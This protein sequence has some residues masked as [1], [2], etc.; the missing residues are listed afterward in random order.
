MRPVSSIASIIR[1]GQWRAAGAALACACVSMGAV[2]LYVLHQYSRHA[3]ELVAHSL[4]FASEPA[5]RFKDV[6][7]LQELVQQIAQQEQLAWVEVRDARGQALL[8]YER[9]PSGWLDEMARHVDRLFMPVPALASVD[10]DGLMLGA[11]Q[12]RSDGHFLMRYLIGIGLALGLCVF[13]TT[14]AI[15]LSSRRLAQSIMG[16]VNSFVELTRE[17]RASR[18]F[19]RRA[20]PTGVVEINALADDFNSLLDELQTQQRRVSARHSDLRQ[21]NAALRHA[22]LHDGLTQLPNRAYLLQRMQEVFNR[23]REQG[24]RAGLLFVDVDKFKQ[25]N[26][27]FGHEAGDAFLKELALRLQASV[28]ETDFVARHGG[29]EF[30]VMLSPLLEGS[31]VRACAARI[32]E[33]LLNPLHLKSGAEIVMGVTIGAAIFP[34]HGSTIDE[35]IHSADSAMYQAKAN[36]RGSLAL[37]EGSASTEAVRKD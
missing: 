26:D 31:E 35:L 17:V 12:L 20:A 5:V 33:A 18:S 34:D 15:V 16:P 2:S 10:T 28:R 21:A 8:S 11:I 30:I 22:S 29:D 6:E 7:A 19:E 13:V 23:C 4:A 27:D 9:P 1:R 37:Y 14:A 25:V 24:L 36:A 32:H 3:M